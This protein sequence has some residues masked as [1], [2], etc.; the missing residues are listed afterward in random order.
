V[1]LAWLV[2]VLFIAVPSAAAAPVQLLPASG[3]PGLHATLVATD[4]P[5]RSSVAV[6]V[7]HGNVKRVQAND[8]GVMTT[9]ELIPSR[10]RGRVEVSLQDARGDR[11]LL[12]Y[13]V[14]S[15]WAPV[16]T[17]ASADWRGR[18]VRVA[19]DFKLGKLLTMMRVRGLEPGARVAARY[20]GRRVARAAAGPGG[21][22]TL[23]AILPPEATGRP[24]IV[25]D[26]RR[27]L[28]TTLPT[29]PATAVVA[30]DI[31]CRPPYETYE[32]HC[33]HAEV[34][35]LIDSI[36]PDVVVMPGDIQYDGGKMSE[37]RRSFDLSWGQLEMPLR[38]TPG[39]HE[40]RVQ[41]ARD[42]FDYFEMQ[43]GG[44]R[45][46]SWYAYTLGYW[47]FIALNSNCEEKRVDCGPQSEQEQWLRA[48][49]AAEPFRCTLAYW[50]HPR[51]SSGFHG[52]DPRFASVWRTLDQAGA[53]LVLTGHDHHY[54]R[55]EPQDENGQRTDTGLREFIVG[56]G[57]SAMSVIREPHVP[58]SVYSQNREFGVLRLRL[59]GDVY[60]WRFIG[61]NGRT[62]DQGV[63]GCYER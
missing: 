62:F 37:F 29:P 42:Y 27:R 3:Q 40:Y 33:E 28:T 39:N 41:G 53:E 49:L 12:Y 52:S 21:R 13:D 19:T 38:P 55:F 20:D 61:L 50:H 26:G 32:D 63:G 45:P 17:F 44:W 43:S 47:R 51:Y 18:V 9:R 10:A 48:N 30:G 22:A 8:A 23:S 15:R 24:L 4:L 34:A 11:A 25:T 58:H 1:A 46:P 60:T 56:T 14:K 6:R 16:A 57:G 5:P 7:D 31:A 59:Y 54:E 36:N 35:A 2:L